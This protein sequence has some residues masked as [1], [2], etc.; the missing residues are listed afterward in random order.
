[1]NRK[2]SGEGVPGSPFGTCAHCNTALEPGERYPVETR[3]EPDGE[4]ELYSFC[5]EACRRAWLTD[6]ETTA[7]HQ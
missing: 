3:G 4:L 1:M 6:H 7:D 5:D 2:T